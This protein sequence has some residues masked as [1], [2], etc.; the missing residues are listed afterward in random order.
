MGSIAT[1]MLFKKLR[2]Q[3]RE[4]GK[5][6][7]MLTQSNLVLVQDL[8]ATS[9]RFQFDILNN[10]GTPKSWEIRLSQ[11]D[12][13]H[14]QGLQFFLTTAGATTD[15]SEV[16]LMTYPNQVTLGVAPPVDWRNLWRGE[17][18]ITINNVTVVQSLSSIQ[19]ESVPQ[20]QGVVA[21]AGNAVDQKRMSSD[22]MFN[23]APT[24][25]ISG[26]RKNSLE[27]TIPQPVTLAIA[28]SCIVCVCSGI[29][30]IGGSSF[31]S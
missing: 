7:V 5:P 20:T 3:Y 21:G 18:N 12:S 26:S 28:N 22:T 14:L 29:V 4:I 1:Q 23:F 2:E 31:Q 24:I 15:D 16:D 11:N 17:F 13:F 19:F 25:N 8:V 6:D 10:E 27:L 9:S 30:A